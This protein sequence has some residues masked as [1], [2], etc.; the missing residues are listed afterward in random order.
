MSQDRAQAAAGSLQGARVG[1][2]RRRGLGWLI[3][4]VVLLALTGGA[5]WAGS[6]SESTARQEALAAPPPTAL[7]SAPVVRRVLS[8]T[9]VATGI[10]SPSQTYAVGADTTEVPSAEPTVTGVPAKV[11][12]VIRNGAQVLEVAGRPLFVFKGPVPMYRDLVSG[13][14]GKDVAEL[15]AALASLGYKVPR[16]VKLGPGTLAAAAAFYSR[17]GYSMMKAAIIPITEVAFVPDL[18]ATVTALNVSLGSTVTTDSLTLAAGPAVL[19]VTLP[20][21]DIGE[22]S[23]GDPAS[24]AL[25][26]GSVSGRLTSVGNSAPVDSQSRSAPTGTS[27]SGSA[28]GLQAVV[29]LGAHASLKDLGEVAAVTITPSKS[30]GPVLAVPAA[31]VFSKADGQTYV[32]TVP[33]GRVPADG[34]RAGKAE[35]DVEVTTG[36]SASGY[37][38]VTPRGASLTPGQSVVIGIQQSGG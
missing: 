32:T 34:V 14:S 17:A 37:I 27:G 18:P 19:D 36:F 1:H 30:Q 7:L 5:W 2:P 22:V 21:G 3:A 9:V 20:S 25:G 8:N 6:H 23:S 38:A 13:D 26:S 4:L 15:Q 28:A 33:A 12:A 11:G 24:V 10:V 35:T 31:A 29:A 16:S